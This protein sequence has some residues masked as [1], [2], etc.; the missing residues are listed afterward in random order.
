MSNERFSIAARLRSFKFAIS[1]LSFVLR[2]QHNA[3][4][5]IAISI[6]VVVAGFVFGLS[7]ADWL[8]ILIAMSIVWIAETFNTAVEFVCDVVSPEFNKNVAK[9]KDIAA[10]AVL[11]SAVFAVI[12]G[13]LVFIPYLASW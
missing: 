7:K 3:H 5:H 12:V 9:A 10:G 8:A 1:G 11:I 4:V 6:A 2:S 13:A